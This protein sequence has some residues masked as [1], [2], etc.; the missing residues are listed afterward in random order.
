MERRESCKSFKIGLTPVEVSILASIVSEESN[1][2]D[3]QPVIAGVYLNRLKRGMK[4]QA[5]PTIKF[6]LNDPS[7]KRILYKHLTIDS[8]YNTY[9]HNGLPPGPIVIPQKST[10]DAV[11]NYKQHNYLYFCAAPTLNGSHNFARNIT[12]HNKNARAYQRAISL[13]N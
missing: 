8:P 4:L 1:I 2:K 12:E 3:E 11:L 5:D 9:I 13:K 7:V 10:I 6:I